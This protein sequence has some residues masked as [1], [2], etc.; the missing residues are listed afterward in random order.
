MLRAAMPEPLQQLAPDLWVAS[1]SLPM[2]IGDIG[3]RMTVIRAG[4]GELLLHS[5]VPLDAATRDALDRL[6]RVRWI[7]GPS[8]VHHFSLADYASAYPD[9]RLCAAPGLPEKRRDLRFHEVLDDAAPPPWGAG[10]PIRMLR[11]AP[12][13]NELVFFHPGSRTLVL[14]DL[15][16]NVP[17]DGGGARVFH[18]LVGATGRFGPHRIVR[19]G[20]RDRAAACASLQAMREWDFDRVIVSHG[21]VLERGGKDAFERAFAPW[22]EPGS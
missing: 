12:A 19:L 22:L 11:G 18:R 1:R 16:F 9:A 4:G 13:M 7:V 8:K 6:G 15:A 20:I 14:T 21:E 3:C 17:A 5:P 2:W 10:L